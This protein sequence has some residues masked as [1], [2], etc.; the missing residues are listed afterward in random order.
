VENV[1]DEPLNALGLPLLE[2]DGG[3]IELSLV[4]NFDDVPE[5]LCVAIELSLTETMVLGSG[6]LL[7]GTTADSVRGTLVVGVARECGLSVDEMETTV[8]FFG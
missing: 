2:P 1:S 8:S 6:E 5:S 3:S 7:V 4:C